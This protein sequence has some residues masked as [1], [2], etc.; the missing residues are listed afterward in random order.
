MKTDTFGFLKGKTVANVG[1]DPPHSV[2]TWRFTD[3]SVVSVQRCGYGGVE[4]S[5]TVPKKVLGKKRV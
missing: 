4:M 5:V 3:G 2:L 1:W